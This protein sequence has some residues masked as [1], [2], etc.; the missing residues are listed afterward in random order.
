MVDYSNDLKRPYL[1][2]FRAESIIN[3]RTEIINGIEQL[4]LVVLEGKIDVLAKDDPFKTKTV[5]TWKVLSIEDGVYYVRNYLQSDSGEFVLESEFTPL[6][7]DARFAFIPFF[8]LTTNGID[9]CYYKPPLL[10]FVN[11]N[12]GH[13]KNSADFENMLHWTGAKTIITKEYGKDTIPIGGAMDMPKDGDA[14]FLEASS[15][16]GLKDEL[17]H[18]EEQMAAMGSAVISGKGRYVS[19]AETAEITSQGEYATLADIS[20]ACS[21]AME[22]IMQLFV[23]WSGSNEDV[24]VKYNVDFELEDIAAADLT[25]FVQA[26]FSGAISYDTFFYNLQKK[27]VYPNKKTK[28]SELED[29]ESDQARKLENFEV[30][31]VNS[32]LG[33]VSE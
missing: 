7:N 12:L 31:E 28:E 13:Y 20:N 21:N 33:T 4:A 22:Y 27:E 8:I 14:F 10:D 15:D 23:E 6:I 24:K 5:E 17:R 25:A 29:I 9:N 2:M 30:D 11:V 3:Y 18:K 26:Y 1:S 16:S 32:D 19:S